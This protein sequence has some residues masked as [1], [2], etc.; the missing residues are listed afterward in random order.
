MMLITMSTRGI[1]DTSNIQAEKNFHFLARLFNSYSFALLPGRA[2][3]IIIYSRVYRLL[4]TYII[5]SNH[6]DS[7]V[8][9]PNN[10]D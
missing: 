4:C 5:S 10:C 8:N 2:L 3:V 7:T 1:V 6:T 9:R